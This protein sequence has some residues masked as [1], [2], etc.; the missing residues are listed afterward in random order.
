MMSFI[1]TFVIDE[2]DAN[3][4]MPFASEKDK[5]AYLLFLKSLL[6]SKAYVEL[7]Y[8][9]GILPIAKYS[10]GS[11]LNMFV[12]YNMATRIRVGEYFGFSEEEVTMLFEE[13]RQKTKRPRVTRDEIYSAMVV[14]GLLT[15]E[16]G[17]VFI[18]NKELMDSFAMMMRGWLYS[19]IEGWPYAGRGNCADQK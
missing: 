15:Y 2:W 3:F 16:D 5:P 14:Y 12:E 7:A 17:R 19:G 8:M 9:T 10:D 13:Y 18:P 6:K 1:L 4:H 11:E